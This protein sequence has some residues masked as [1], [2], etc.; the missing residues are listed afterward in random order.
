MLMGMQHSQF[1]QD[2]L[3]EEGQSMHAGRDD[4]STLQND[5]LTRGSAPFT[6]ANKK[7]IDALWAVYSKEGAASAEVLTLKWC[8]FSQNQQHP[9]CKEF[10]SA[11]VYHALNDSQSAYPQFNETKGHDQLLQF[12]VSMNHAVTEQIAKHTNH[13]SK[14]GI[15][16]RINE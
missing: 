1:I 14:I 12:L 4:S 3:G 11:F 6:Q 5:S 9:N 16:V 8:D 7:W 2:V 13:L 15:I 10:T